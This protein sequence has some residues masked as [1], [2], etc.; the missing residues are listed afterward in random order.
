MTADASEHDLEELLEFAERLARDAGSIALSY[1][2]KNPQ[3]EQKP[4]GSIVTIADREAE[5]RMRR[6][7][8]ERYPGDGIV[9]EE[10]GVRR[11]SSGRR[12]IIDPIDGT[13]AYA[14]GVPLFGVLV[15]AEI[16]GEA[17]VGVAHM[18]VLDEMV[19]AAKGF[20]CRWNGRRAKT[21]AIASVGAALIVCG[22]FHACDMHG[23]G[24]AAQRLQAAAQERRGWGD[25]YGHI[26]VATGRAEIALD[27]IMSIW[28]CAALAPIVQEAGG[29]FTDWRGR[30]TIDGG[31]GISTNGALFNDVMKLVRASA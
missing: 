5:Q 3:R 24:E 22:D 12:W 26:L 31:S 9:G 10:F 19:A 30:S 20:G 11:G 18:P 4:D 6:R 14:H 7:I 2:G 16:D 29:T 23:F 28:D 21:S 27:P 17:A 13:F 15:G 1:F 8:E 25:C